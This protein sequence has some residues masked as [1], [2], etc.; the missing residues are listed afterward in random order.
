VYSCGSPISITLGHYERELPEQ[1][2]TIASRNPLR[3][4]GTVAGEEE[5]ATIVVDDSLDVCSG[6]TQR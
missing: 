5:T 6:G 4:R 3:I 1:T 2:T